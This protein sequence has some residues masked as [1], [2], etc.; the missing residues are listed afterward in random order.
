[1]KTFRDGNG[2]EWV[3][4]INVT[5]IKRVRDLAGFDLLEVVEGTLIDKLIRDPVLLCDVIYAACKPEADARGIDDRQFGQAMFGDAIAH[6]SDAL[7]EELVNFCQNPRDRAILAKVL[8]KTRV[9][10]D[11]ARDLIEARLNSGEIEKAVDRVLASANASS[12]NVP[13][14]AE[15]TLADS[16]SAN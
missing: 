7:L 12:G 9:A 14:S 2:K 8:E 6:A 1:M 15:S 11:K 10:M 5:S 13:V 3:I 4:E 16:L